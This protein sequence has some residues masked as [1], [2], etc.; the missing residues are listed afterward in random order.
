VSRQPCASVPGG[1][2][3]VGGTDGREGGRYL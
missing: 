1:A 3:M 2:E